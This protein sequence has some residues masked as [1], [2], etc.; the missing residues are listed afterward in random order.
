[1]S[2]TTTR[3]R[4]VKPA[5]GSARWISPLTAGGIGLLAINTQVYS[6]AR[7]EG[8]HRLMKADGTFYDVADEGT[9][10]CPDFTYRR[11]HDGT[12]CKHIQALKASLKKLAAPITLRELAVPPAETPRPEDLDAVDVKLVKEEPHFQPAA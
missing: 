3:R 11:S 1:M 10:D 6:V 2:T 9:C 5:T 8:G 4:T 7:I 12:A